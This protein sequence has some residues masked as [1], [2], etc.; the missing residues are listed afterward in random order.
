ML[1]TDWL[2]HTSPAFRLMIATSWL[3]PDRWRMQQETA[4]QEAFDAG[5]NW[6]EY[7]LLVDRHRTPA[8][9]WAALSR[10][11]GVVRDERVEQ[12]MKRRSD[13]CRIKAMQHCRLLTQTLTRF[14]QAGIPVMPLK[15]QILSH[16]LYGDVGLRET[17]DID[18]EVPRQQ[19]GRAQ[20]CL[21]N[22]EWQLEKTFFPM[23]PRQ[24]QSFLENE[25]H[26]NFIHEKTGR[27]LELHWRNQW[28][29]PD[30]TRARWA[31]SAS[32]VWQGCSIQ[33]MHSSDMTLYLCSHG[34]LHEWFR[35]KW[36]GD[37][38]RA[39]ILGILDWKAAWEQAQISRQTRVL[40]AGIYLLEQLYGLPRPDLPDDAWK[41]SPQTL[42][43]IPRQAL[44]YFGEPSGRTS[45]AKLR[46]R[47]RRSRYER[48]LWPAKAWRASLAELFYG[49]E[50]FRT[51]PLPDRLFWAYKPMRPVLWL[52]RWLQQIGHRTRCHT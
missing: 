9:S 38:A 15:G 16:A 31:R 29:D 52:C 51:L 2:Q 34:G 5:V 39:H 8:L 36:I 33:V 46:F 22:G 45:A 19:L 1:M 28:E 41:E 14:N 32:A 17:L 4:M 10:V 47:I 35:A 42:T 40:L 13:A 26:I 25:Q 12:E 37:L 23:T 48:L 6:E 18:L 20:D 24:W 27:L 49:R 30:A 44:H 7:L 50:D 3:A 11:Q 43:T 21:V